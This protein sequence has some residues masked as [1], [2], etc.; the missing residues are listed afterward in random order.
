MYRFILLFTVVLAVTAPAHAAIRLVT[1]L[2]DSGPGSLREAILLAS[3]G[4]TVQMAP[5]LAGSI[6]LSSIV[7]VT[8]SLRIEGSGTV[9][10]NGRNLTRLLNTATGIN[11]TLSG[12]VFEAGIGDDGGAIWNRANLQII[13]C[14]FR[15]NRASA[16]GGGVYTAGGT[17]NVQNSRFEGNTALSEGG[18]L[19]LD[20]GAL[21]TTVQDTVFSGSTVTAAGG[22][23]R[24]VSSQDLFV[25]RSRF[26]GNQ[27]VSTSATNTLGGAIA[28]QSGTLIV[29]DSVFSGN[30]ASY[31]GALYSAHLGTPTTLRVQRSLFTANTADQAGGG[32]FVFGADAVFTNVT[33][34][35]NLATQGGGGVALQ[36][37]SSGTAN[38]VLIN[39]T[40][41][42]NRGGSQAGGVVAFTGELQLRS[43]L[44]A[45]N[46]ATTN[47]D[48][49]AGFL[50]LGNNL[51]QTRGTSTGYIPSDLANGTNP[52]IG[53]LQPNGGP[54]ASILPAAGSPAINAV[55]PSNCATVPVDQRGYPRPATACD[56]GAIEVGAQPAP[57]PVFSSGFE[58]AI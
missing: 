56:I 27:A 8:K 31:A 54:S 49:T 42:Y 36:S 50:S 29:E 7:V 44:I 25:Q 16:R 11:V 30:R 33:F 23:I 5:D 38:V 2:E 40:V 4:D 22:A 55:S 12:L 17:L 47:A 14:V 1:S 34:A 58:P 3:S 57:D 35:T 19:F 37:S 26:Y 15:N 39:N 28:S 43:T 13:D 10:L 51:V 21:T 32:V 53:P 46:L 41:A 45:A 18:A 20:F 6:P 9:S 52:Q 48:I 24:H